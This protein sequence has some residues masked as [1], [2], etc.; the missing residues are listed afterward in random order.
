[1]G[2]KD[3]RS[4]VVTPEVCVGCVDY[5]EKRGERR[6]LGGPNETWIRTASEDTFDISRWAGA[7][8]MPWI[9]RFGNVPAIA[10]PAL[11]PG[12][13]GLR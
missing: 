10:A 12:N 6:N 9:L 7:G 5:A 13:V 11:R 3:L 4:A 8:V 1:M 2:E